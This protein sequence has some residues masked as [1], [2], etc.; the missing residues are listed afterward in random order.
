VTI[1]YLGAVEPQ[2]K[3]LLH[4]LVWSQCIC[5]NRYSSLLPQALDHSRTSTKDTSQPT[6]L[7]YLSVH[8]P[9]YSLGRAAKI[10]LGACF[11]LWLANP[12]IY[13]LIGNVSVQAHMLSIGTK[14]SRMKWPLSDI[15]AWIRSTTVP[16]PNYLPCP[17]QTLTRGMGPSTVIH[18]E[19]L[20]HSLHCS[21]HATTL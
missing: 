4:F 17:D 12:C 5:G 7:V 11:N 2:L 18:N 15:C 1:S 9:R 8:S 3:S 6:L 21:C 14:G 10:Q 19:K 20:L 16:M 13:H